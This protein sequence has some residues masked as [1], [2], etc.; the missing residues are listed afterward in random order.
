VVKLFDRI[1]LFEAVFTIDEILF[2][3]V[4]LTLAVFE[5]DESIPELSFFSSFLLIISV[6]LTSDFNGFIEVNDDSTLVCVGFFYNSSIILF[7]CSITIFF[8]K[9]KKKNIYI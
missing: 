2:N 4:L 7:S 6:P 5:I 8:I 1:L 3:S 9:K